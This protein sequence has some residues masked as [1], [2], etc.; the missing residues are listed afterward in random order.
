M[1]E[2]VAC[3]QR[4]ARRA[5][6][7]SDR[8]S[9]NISCC[10]GRRP[11][12]QSVL[13]ERNGCA[14]A[15]VGC[16]GAPA[17]PR[18]ALRLPPWGLQAPGV[19]ASCC[20]T[21]AT[22]SMVQGSQSHVMAGTPSQLLPP[23]PLPTPLSRLLL[24]HAPPA[25]LR[26]GTAP[27]AAALLRP[28][29]QPWMAARRAPLQAVSCLSSASVVNLRASRHWKSSLCTCNASLNPRPAFGKSPAAPPPPLPQQRKYG[30]CQLLPTP[31]L[32]ILISARGGATP[33][34]TAV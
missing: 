23:G 7:R 30:R 29:A 17:P 6:S 31:A 11:G 26:N 3:G 25:A 12:I 20:S 9:A 33:V 2:R 18:L 1:A 10:S 14:S 8:P 32:L 16:A 5:D 27:A 28:P 19:A 4:H 34:V 13:L 24:L 15:A 21:A 22:P